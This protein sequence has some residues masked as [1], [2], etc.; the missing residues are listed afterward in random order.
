MLLS[1]HVIS[2]CDKNISDCSNSLFPKKMIRILSFLIKHKYTSWP[3]EKTLSE[4]HLFS[5]FIYSFN[6]HWGIY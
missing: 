2:F 3:E 4:C 6:L 5:L 1:R